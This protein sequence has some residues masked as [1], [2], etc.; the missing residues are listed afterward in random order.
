MANDYGY[1]GKG[2]SGY[3][4]Y[5]Q[6]FNAAHGGGGGGKGGGSNGGCLGVVLVILLAG[7]VLLLPFV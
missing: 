2:S 1:F 4:H 5:M 6:T 7:R 3:A